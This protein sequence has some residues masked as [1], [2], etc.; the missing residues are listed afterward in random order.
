MRAMKGAELRCH[1][2]KLFAA[3]VQEKFRKGWNLSYYMTNGHHLV[4][5]S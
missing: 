4:M 1:G 2:K 5:W 3:V